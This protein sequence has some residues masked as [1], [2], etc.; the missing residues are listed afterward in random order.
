[1]AIPRRG[2]LE[3]FNTRITLPELMS[4]IGGTGE[5]TAVPPSSTSPY[6][7]PP[8]GARGYD[9][10]DQVV[11][12]PAVVPATGDFGWDR[13]PSGPTAIFGLWVSV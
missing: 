1:M 6:A 11:P 12:R 10:A 13:P 9:P 7:I 5:G 3:T 8:A 4:F 2:L